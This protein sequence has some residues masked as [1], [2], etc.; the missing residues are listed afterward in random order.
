ML[1]SCAFASTENSTIY[2]YFV[3]D[4]EKLRLLRGRDYFSEECEHAN[5]E[6][7]LCVVDR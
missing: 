2:M 1:E 5:M 4:S 6:Q 7:Q 3:L